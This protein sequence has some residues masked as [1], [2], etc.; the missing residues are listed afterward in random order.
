M[1]KKQK[2]LMAVLLV[3]VLVVSGCSSSTSGSAVASNAP[4]T[5]QVKEVVIDAY[6]WG[7][8]Q[9]TVQI[10][11]GDQ[12]RVTVRSSSGAHG[13]A[14]PDF[15]VQTGRIAAGSE[16]VIEF[17]ADKSGS[18]KYFCNIP[19]GHGHSSMSGQLIVN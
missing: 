9:N 11:K 10:N 5:G 2:Y 6:S 12:V 18:F 14:F 15:G 1:K 8:N 3:L 17:I 16:E 19:C 4:S 7:F 13:V